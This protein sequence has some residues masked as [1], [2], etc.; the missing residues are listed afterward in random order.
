MDAG[1][2]SLR[3]EEVPCILVTVGMDQSAETL[4]EIRIELTVVSVLIRPFVSA[5]PVVLIFL[6]GSYV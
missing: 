1:T 6:K 5:F 2:M 4:L 3:L